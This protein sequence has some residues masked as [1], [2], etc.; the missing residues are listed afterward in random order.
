MDFTGNE[1]HSISLAEAAEMTAR[2]RGQMTEEQIKGGFFGAR[3]I[4]TILDQSDC[5][6]IRYYYGLDSNNKQVLVLVGVL[7]NQDDIVD[8]ILA[9]VSLPCPTFCGSDNSLNS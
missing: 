9:E 7:A 5:V 4:M 8:G 1:D 3:A 6:G 2:Y